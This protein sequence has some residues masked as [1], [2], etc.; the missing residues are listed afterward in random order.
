MAFDQPD[1]VAVSG[2]ALIVLG[3][4]HLLVHRCPFEERLTPAGQLVLGQPAEARP[5]LARPAMLVDR[6]LLPRLRRRPPPAGGPHRPR[7]FGHQAPR[8]GPR[9]PSPTP[10]PRAPGRPS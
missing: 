5:G 4:R 9:P 3:P 10:R 6:A 1:V 7:S 2:M 8:R